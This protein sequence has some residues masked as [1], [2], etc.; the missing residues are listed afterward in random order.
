MLCCIIGYRVRVCARPVSLDKWQTGNGLRAS[1]L[2]RAQSSM[3]CRGVARVRI[4]RRLSV[5]PDGSRFGRV[6]DGVGQEA[7]MSA[8]EKPFSDSVCVCHELGGD[9]RA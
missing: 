2:V 1:L 3:S 9:R 7:V 5:S 8:E 4:C 6:K